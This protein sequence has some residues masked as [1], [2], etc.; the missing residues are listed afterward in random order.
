MMLAIMTL[1]VAACVSGAFKAQ[2]QEQDDENRV[3]Q[4]E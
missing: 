2:V 4:P 3:N 1:N